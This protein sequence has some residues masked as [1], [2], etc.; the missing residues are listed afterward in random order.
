MTLTAL[1]FLL[2]LLAQPQPQPQAAPI[3]V[4]VS[5]GGKFAFDWSGEFEDGSPGAE[6]THVEFHYKPEPPI[7]E[8]HGHTTVS[9]PLVVK[10]GENIVPMSIALEG[11]AAGLYNLGVRV[12]GVG[13]NP[14]NY[15]HPD[16]SVMVRVKNPARPANL[17]VK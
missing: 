11:V 13:G 12:I 14:S 8:G 4:G 9:V 7:P 17:R 3:D 6:I 16:L 2:A 15:S 1:A 10:V 5:S